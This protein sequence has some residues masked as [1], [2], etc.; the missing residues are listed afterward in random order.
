MQ[1]HQGAPGTQLD[2]RGAEYEFGPYENGIVSTL[3]GR[4]KRVGVVQI[5]AAVLQLLGYLGLFFSVNRGAGG[6][7]GLATHIPVALAF[8]VGGFL[9]YGAARPF[10]AIVDTQGSDV[11]LLMKAFEK[12]AG[13]MTLLTISFVVATVIWAA[14]FAL[15]LAHVTR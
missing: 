7:I 9:L 3:A 12:L 5:V 10:R 1:S 13:M 15:R 14:G 2:A 6:P 4:M 8:V 11:G